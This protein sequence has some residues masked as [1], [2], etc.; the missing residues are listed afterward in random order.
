MIKRMLG[1]VSLVLLSVIA[2]SFIGTHKAAAFYTE[3]CDVLAD[4]SSPGGG[5]AANCQNGQMNNGLTNL[6]GYSGNTLKARFIS[7]IKNYRSSGY[8]FQ[9]VGAAYIEAGLQQKGGNWED[10]INDS[11]VTLKIGNIPAAYRCDNTA[12]YAPSNRVVSTGD[13]ATT[14]ASLL[15]YDG[16]KLVYIIKLDCGNPMGNLKGPA[17]PKP[18][19]WNLTGTTTVSDT[20]IFPTQPTTFRNYIKN[21][22][23]G[24]ANSHWYVRWC[25]D[26]CSG[27]YSSGYGAHADGVDASIPANNANQ[28]EN[29]WTYTPDATNNH[30]RLC[31]WIAYTNDTQT[32]SASSRSSMKCVTIEQASPQCGT[33]VINPNP[34]GPTDGYT[35]KTYVKGFS[36]A[37]EAGIV[38]AASNYYVH[39]SGPT[40]YTGGP[41]VT[42]ANNNVTPVTVGS[43]TLT[44]TVTM[45]ATGN[46]GV[47]TVTWGITG[48]YGNINCPAATGPGN[49]FTVAYTPYFSVKG[50]DVSVGNG[51]N[52]ADGCTGND[53]ADIAG[54]NTDAG[55][56]DG[57]GSELGAIATGHITDFVSGLGLSGGASAQ[58][59]HG[60][61]LANYLGGSYAG[62]APAY[63]GSYGAAT[64]LPCVHD[65]QADAPSGMANLGSNISSATLS[66]LATNSYT[67]TAAGSP[68]TVTIG[69]G[70][71]IVLGSGK[72]ITIY[73]TGYVY[74]KS[75]IKYNYSTI[76][77]IP[78]FRLIV[79]GT[80]YIAPNVTDLHGIYIAQKYAYDGNT[81]GGIA[82]CSTASGTHTQDYSICGNPLVFTGAVAA[83]NVLWLD[84]THGDIKDAPV[85]P[86]E[87]FRYSPELWLNSSASSVLTYQA[88]AGLPPVL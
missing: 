85:E 3:Y 77:D 41:K 37:T 7:D 80:I 58:G 56:Y 9:K 35:L 40:P 4:P 46:V 44:A 6:N 84:R 65:Y 66:G 10:N 32:G 11:S 34:P 42:Y 43:T 47:Y 21:A 67:G 79:K 74:I 51:F 5:N 62:P 29:S 69:D 17:P 53:N 73:A 64:T 75:N 24:V 15:I 70:S 49:Q 81:G 48:P 52:W 2:I 12:Y 54:Q 18:V 63:G 76:Q 61:S 1:G 14:L 28:L 82:T 55:T 22:G 27:G 86:A 33:M 57:A 30:T 68:A 39:V 88:F 83:E 36:N 45:P 60:L 31:V 13:C 71:D 50:G 20:D 59:G 87:T 8:G 38:N 25:W 23:P 19:T 72:Q 16:G 26:A 78:Q